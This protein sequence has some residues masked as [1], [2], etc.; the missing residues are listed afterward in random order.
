[1]RNAGRVSLRRRVRRARGD[2]PCDDGAH[3]ARARADRR[4]SVRGIPT[5]C[6]ALRSEANSRAARPSLRGGDARRGGRPRAP[7]AACCGGRRRSRAAR[8]ASCSGCPR[9]RG[10]RLPISSAPC[11]RGGSRLPARHASSASDSARRSPSILIVNSGF[12]NTLRLPVSGC[13]RMT[14][15]RI[16]GAA[17]LAIALAP[18]VVSRVAKK[19]SALADECVAVSPSRNVLQASATALRTPRTCRPTPCR[20]RRRA[21]SRRAASRRAAGALG[22]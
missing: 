14:G 16:G 22:R 8:S 17:A 13:T 1:M 9:T 18:P 5:V 2:D 6:R 15:W 11:R 10:R 19:P 12:T 21:R 20:R 7:R 4:L 3:A